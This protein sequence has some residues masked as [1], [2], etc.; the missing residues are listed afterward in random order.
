MTKGLVICHHGQF[1]WY[2]AVA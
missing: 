1:K 2:R